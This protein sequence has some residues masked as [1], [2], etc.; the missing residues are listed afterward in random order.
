MKT[1]AKNCVYE[2]TWE[3]HTGAPLLNAEGIKICKTGAEDNTIQNGTKNDTT[4]QVSGVGDLTKDKSQRNG[5]ENNKSNIKGE[6]SASSKTERQIR[7]PHTNKVK[8]TDRNHLYD[9]I[10]DPETQK[11]VILGHRDV[12]S[13]EDGHTA[14]QNTEITKGVAIS[15]IQ[16]SPS[17]QHIE[18]KG[19]QLPN[20][21]NLSRNSPVPS[22]P[23]KIQVQKKYGILISDLPKPPPRKFLSLN[24]K[25]PKKSRVYDGSKLNRSQSDMGFG[26]LVNANNIH[27]TT[28]ESASSLSAMSVDDLA[29]WLNTLH[30]KCVDKFVEHSIDGAKLLTSTEEIFQ[31][32]DIGMSKLDIL[33]L[34]KFI[35]E[36]C[37]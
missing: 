9:V 19:L 29:H 36:R 22:L 15:D 20:D 11:P 32:P 28:S 2:L 17:E 16:V 5:K 4:K 12:N 27:P 25:D 26:E 3:S 30:M 37:V 8:A 14:P 31:S 35:R 1:K 10:L 13:S 24:R 7:K 6:E 33:R 34:K 18:Q 23:P 21:S